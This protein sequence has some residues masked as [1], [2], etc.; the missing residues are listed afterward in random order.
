L[1]AAVNVSVRVTDTAFG[2]PGAGISVALQRTTLSG[3]ID[4]AKGQTDLNGRLAVWQ[5]TLGLPATF[6]L[7][8]DLDRYYAA[9]GSVAVF[10]RATVVFRLSNTDEDLYLTILTSP[11]LVVIS[12]GGAD[13]L[14]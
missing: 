2:G 8:F 5:G 1:V 11:N 9:L 10:H 12:R 13:E 14:A 7:E 6:Q 4:L 3:W